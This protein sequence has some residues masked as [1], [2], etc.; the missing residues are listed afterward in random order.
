MRILLAEDDALLGDGRCAGLRQRGFR[1]TGCAM[2]K[3]PSANCAP[4]P[5]PPRCWTWGCRAATGW[6][7]WPQAGHVLSREQFEQQV[8]GWGQE[9]ESNAVE[10]HAHQLRR[11]L[12][13][14]LIQ[15]ARGVGYR[16]PRDGTPA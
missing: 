9:V 10:V 16:V 6:T 14:A 2:A 8:Y 7:S 5:T 15:T 1:W 11:K 12:G 13:P 3:R 4:S